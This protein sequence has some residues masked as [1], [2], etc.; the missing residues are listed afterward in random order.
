[1]KKKRKFDIHQVT[2]AK[3]KNPVAFYEK[4]VIWPLI[5]TVSL[6]VVKIWVI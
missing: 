5:Q 4:E 2:H 6:I 3:K 1:M